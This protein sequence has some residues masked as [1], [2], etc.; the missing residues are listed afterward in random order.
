MIFTQLGI[1]TSTDWLQTPCSMW[2]L[3]ADYRKLEDFAKNISVTNDIAERGIRIITD[4]IDKSENEDQRRA[5]L[6]V[7]ENYRD[8]VPDLKKNSLKN[9]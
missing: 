8:Q 1:E 2:P 7:V 9:C 3:F 5:L 6:Q 4:F